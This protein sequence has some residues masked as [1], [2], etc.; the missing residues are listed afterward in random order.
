MDTYWLRFR[1]RAEGTVKF[2][3]LLVVTFHGYTYLLGY[4]AVSRTFLLILLSLLLGSLI[5]S[6]QSQ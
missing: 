5:V 2:V 1:G 4:E 6:I 3:Y